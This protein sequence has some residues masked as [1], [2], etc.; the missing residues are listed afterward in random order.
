[1]LLRIIFACL[2]AVLIAAG[3]AM[4]ADG[5]NLHDFSSNTPARA[6]SVNENFAEV[7]DAIPVIWASIDQDPAAVAFTPGPVPGAIINDLPGIIVPDSGILLISGSVFV[8]NDD[9]TS[10]PFTLNPLIDGLAPD[11]HT[12]QAFFVAAPDNTLV[13]EG[14]TLSYTYAVAVAATTY[15]VSQ[16]LA[17]AGG[18]TSRFTYNRNNL[19]V[20]FF[21]SL[22]GGAP[23]N[24]PAIPPGAVILPPGQEDG[25][26]SP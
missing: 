13:A 17:I 2:L 23:I 1:M 21:P 6:D 16:D 15:D 26:I 3:S 8:N 11:G 12:S 14:F 4:A 10:W 25:D 19:T 20:V 7:E 5:L 9:P 18:G 22:P 24:T